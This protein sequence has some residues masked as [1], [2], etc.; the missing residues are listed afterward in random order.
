M[1][2]FFFGPESCLKK[3][4][5]HSSAETLL[6]LVGYMRIYPQKLYIYEQMSEKI[7]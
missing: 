5:H 6:I 3:L 1:V 4:N 2:F 7:D